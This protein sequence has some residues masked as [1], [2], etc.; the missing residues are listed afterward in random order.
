MF[1]S[2]N[3][4]KRL[5]CYGRWKNLFNQL[6]KNDLRTC[7]SLLEIT[8]VQEDDDTTGC[9]LDYSYFKKHYKMIV[10]DLSKQ[11]ALDTDTKAIQEI[12]L[13]GNLDRSGNTTIFF[14]IK[15]ARE[16]ILDFSQ[17]TA[18]LS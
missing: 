1:S 4:I 12:N 11:K 18:R 15:E 3:R 13:T 14:I 5:Q 7:D 2:R 16:I 10:R 9:L 6:I 17:G 8:T